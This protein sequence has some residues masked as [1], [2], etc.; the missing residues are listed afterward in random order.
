MVDF[1]KRMTKKFEDLSNLFTKKN[2]GQYANENS[3]PLNA[4]RK[5]AIIKYEKDSLAEQYLVLY[6]FMLKHL[7]HLKDSTIE[8]PKIKESLEDIAVY[9]LIAS[10]MVEINEEQKSQKVKD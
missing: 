7:S 4:F 5:G 9:C 10:C 8:T 2:S 3:N 1:Y 6:D